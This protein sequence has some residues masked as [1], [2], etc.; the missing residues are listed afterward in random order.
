VNLSSAAIAEI[1]GWMATTVFVAS[2]FFSKPSML[3]LLQMG[4]SVLWMTYGVIIASK[5]VVAANVMVFAAAAWTV[6][7]ARRAVGAVR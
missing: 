7:R 5:P 1:V 6:M 4:G 3:R 2:Y